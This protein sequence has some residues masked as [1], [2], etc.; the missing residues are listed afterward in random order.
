MFCDWWTKRGRGDDTISEYEVCGDIININEIRNDQE[1]MKEDVITFSWSVMSED[2]I[3]DQG[4]KS[5]GKGIRSSSRSWTTEKQ[6][7]LIL[8]QTHLLS[9]QD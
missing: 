3:D 9:G 6:Q 7:N 1:R 5:G 8:Q 2:K 4:N